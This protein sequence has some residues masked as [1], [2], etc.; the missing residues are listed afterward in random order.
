MSQKDLSENIRHNFEWNESENVNKENL[1]KSVN[2][3]QLA[4][5]SKLITLKVCIRK[6]RT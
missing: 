4:L 6:E 2:T 5:R 1:Y 3:L